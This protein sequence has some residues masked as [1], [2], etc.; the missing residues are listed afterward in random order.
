M[1][2]DLRFKTFLLV[3]EKDVSLTVDFRSVIAVGPTDAYEYVNRVGL[4]KCIGTR[5]L[6]TTGQWF[7]VRGPHETIEQ[8]W[9]AALQQ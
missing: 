8:E 6:L 3:H 4:Q 9:K 5:I 1:S 2:I 7:V